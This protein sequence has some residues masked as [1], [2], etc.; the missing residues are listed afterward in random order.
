MKIHYSINDPYPAYRVDL[1]ELFGV[2]LQQL[3]VQTQWSMD[4]P[5]KADSSVKDFFGQVVFLPSD[6]P[7]AL[8]RFKYWCADIRIMLNL[9]RSEVDA[10]QC[11][12]KYIGALAGLVAAK[13]IGVPFFYWCSYPFPEHK[14][15]LADGAKG[16]RKLLLRA[17]GH[18][19]YWVLHKVVMPRSDHV[20]VQSEQ[21]KKDLASIGIEPSK[22]T[23]VLMGV[24]TGM[25]GWAQRNKVEVESNKIVYIGSFASVRKLDTIIRAFSQVVKDVPL[26]K[27]YMVG[28]GDVPSERAAL[29]QLAEDLGLRDSV[30]FTGFV[31]MEQAWMHAKTA[32]VCLSPF[33]PTPILASASP[34]KLVEYMA[35]GR[36]IVC[37]DH[38][39]QSEV[40]K[41]SGVGICV[42][43]NEMAFARAV[44]W[45]LQNGGEAEL[46]ASKGPAWVH[47]NRVYGK[48]A[49]VVY[50]VYKDKIRNGK[51]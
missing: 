51:Q 40:I 33:F 4:A 13:I 39:E 37:N 19:G 22:M 1:T 42:P 44:T 49:E 48:I 32:A 8:R 27:L 3:G 7:R 16:W 18:L 35:L 30:I 10:I 2:E 29:E 15:T 43:W 20:F 45:V 28:D 21:M 36:P 14:L 50:K 5:I 23:P 47:S 38:P 11:R 12:D 9:K 34:T 24:A 41:A 6:G 31:P 26:A 25:L 17:Q 46:L